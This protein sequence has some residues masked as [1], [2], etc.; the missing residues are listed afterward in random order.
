MKNY[1]NETKLSRKKIVLK[2]SY[3][4]ISNKLSDFPKIFD[5]SNIQKELYI[6]NYYNADRIQNNNISKINNC[7]VDNNKFDM[8]LY[9][10]F[11]CCQDVRILKEGHTKFRNNNLKSLNI[12]VDNFIIISALANHYFKLNNLY[13]VQYMEVE[14]CVEI[15]QN[16]ML[17]KIYMIMTH[18]RYILALY[19]G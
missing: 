17:L 5:L 2:D 10:K 1:E 16:I 7:L 13:M 18:A 12:D 3:S 19:I 4:M 9:C 11:Y 8:R 6:Y 15:I 14:I